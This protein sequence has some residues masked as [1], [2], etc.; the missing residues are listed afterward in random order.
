MVPGFKPEVYSAYTPIPKP[1]ASEPVPV[2]PE[3]VSPVT[4]LTSAFGRSRKQKSICF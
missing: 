4:Q 2:I 3:Y 1:T